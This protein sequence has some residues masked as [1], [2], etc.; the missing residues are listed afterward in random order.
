VT[1]VD[2][3]LLGRQLH[4]TQVENSGAEA[5]FRSKMTYLDYKQVRYWR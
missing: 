1:A 3:V 2:T 4:I 5:E